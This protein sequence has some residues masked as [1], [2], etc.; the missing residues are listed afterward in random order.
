MI[1]RLPEGASIGWMQAPPQWIFTHTIRFVGVVRVVIQDG[2][3][4][5]LIQ[6]GKP[7]AY[8]FKHGRIEFNL[9]K[10]TAEEMAEALKI[11]N[12]D[13]QGTIIPLQP[14]RTVVAVKE[15]APLPTAAPPCLRWNSSSPL[16][17]NPCLKPGHPPP[18][19]ACNHPEDHSPARLGVLCPH[20]P[21]DTGGERD[22]G[23]L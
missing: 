13:D 6:K 20:D 9:C 7:L 4:F 21:P 12:V 5:I 14:E 19:Y 10:Y 23:S 11:C 16:P 3:G 22:R 2:E 18:Q 17:Q 1:E 8:Y 15:T